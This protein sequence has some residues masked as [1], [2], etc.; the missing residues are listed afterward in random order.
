MHKAVWR[1]N[2]LETGRV[3]ECRKGTLKDRPTVSVLLMM[4]GK[5]CVRSTQ[6]L[7][8]T[9]PAGSGSPMSRRTV[10]VVTHSAAPAESPAKT[11]FAGETGLC[12]ALG[13]GCVK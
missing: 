6:G 10:S 8:R 9:A 1:Q 5:L 4:L 13:G 3:K 12:R 2:I 7:M 11:S